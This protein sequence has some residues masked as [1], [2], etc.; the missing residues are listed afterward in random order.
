MLSTAVIKT[1]TKV[2]VLATGQPLENRSDFLQRWSH[3]PVTRWTHLR[4]HS[5]RYSHC[6][7]E[8]RDGAQHA[9]EATVKVDFYSLDEARF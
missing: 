6:V 5:K 1:F 8:E 9:A 4:S 7:D 3:T 2:L